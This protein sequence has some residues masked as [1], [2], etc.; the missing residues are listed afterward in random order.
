M[1][2]VDLV[3]PPVGV[4][5]AGDDH[6]LARLAHQVV[7]VAQLVLPVAK[8]ER[9]MHQEDRDVIELELDDEPLDAGIEVMESLAAHPRRRK[10]GIR[11]LADDG[12]QLIHR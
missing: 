5:V 10:K 12:H 8:F 6:G 3:V 2:R 4:E 11:L 7:E 9:Q 1:N